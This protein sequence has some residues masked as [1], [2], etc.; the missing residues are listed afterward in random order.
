MISDSHWWFLYVLIFTGLTLVMFIDFSW[1]IC[2]TMMKNHLACV[3][4]F[5]SDG[6]ILYAYN[7]LALMTVHLIFFKLITLIFILKKV[8]FVRMFIFY[9]DL[10]SRGDQTSSSFAPI[11]S[12]TSASR[13]KAGKTASSYSHARVRAVKKRDDVHKYTKRAK[14]LRV[15]IHKH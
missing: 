15:K 7:L 13:P 1:H 6:Y 9:F 10:N 3:F 2:C 4:T 8:L 14:K 5:Q 12:T 11:L